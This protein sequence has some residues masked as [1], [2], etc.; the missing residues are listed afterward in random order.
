MTLNV[1][2]FIRR[3]LLHVLPERFVKIRY[4]RYYG[5]MGNRN[6]KE[7]LTQCYRLLKIVAIKEGNKDM[8][9]TWQEFLLRVLGIDLMKCPFCE[10][11]RMHT[12]EI[13]LPQRCNSPP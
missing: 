12:K 4:F 9:E 8:H 2:E 10:N 7:M 5:L 13:L 6:R 3:F 11:G 1:F